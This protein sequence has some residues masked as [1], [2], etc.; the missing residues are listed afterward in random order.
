MNNLRV[1]LGVF[2]LVPFVI[3]IGYFLPFGFMEGCAVA[4]LAIGLL[5]GPFMLLCFAVTAILGAF[6]GGNRRR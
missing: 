1:L 2:A 5:V 6:D 3:G 4:I